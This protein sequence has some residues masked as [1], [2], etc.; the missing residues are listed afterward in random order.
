MLLDNPGVLREQRV[1]GDNQFR[2]G[3]LYHPDFCQGHPA[4]FDVSV[5]NTLSSSVISH[6]SV[7]TGAAAAAAG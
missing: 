4:F 3:N 1:S 7:S 2:P 6:A 5:H